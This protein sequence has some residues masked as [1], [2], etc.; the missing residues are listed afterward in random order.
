MP[1]GVGTATEA[2][3][4]AVEEEEA[5]TAGVEVLNIGRAMSPW[6][7]VAAGVAGNNATPL[8]VGPV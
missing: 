5:G 6:N 8:K 7:P 4:E 3:P 1:D 2:L